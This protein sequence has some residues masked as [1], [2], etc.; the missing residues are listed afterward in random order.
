[1]VL[2]RFVLAALPVSPLGNLLYK[3]RAMLSIT[4]I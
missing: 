4:V 1:M 3:A 2:F